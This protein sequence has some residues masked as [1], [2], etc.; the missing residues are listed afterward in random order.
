M[1]KPLHLL[2]R[3]HVIRLLRKLLRIVGL[4]LL[5]TGIV[6]GGAF[7]VFNWWFLP[8]L[9]QFRP[10]LEASL[11]QASGRQV[12]VRALSGEW[13]GVAPRLQLQGLR[14][15]NPVN[16]EALTLQQVLVVPSW[17]SLLSWQPL[18]S[19]IVLQGPSVALVR[20]SDGH[21]LL[22]GFDLSASPERSQSADDEPSANWLLRQKR[23]EIS[24]AHISWEDKQLGLPRLDLQRG[25][26]IL[27]QT[28]LG[29]RLSL[30]GK[31]VATLGKGFDMELSWRGNDLRQWRDWAGSARIRL[32]GAQAGMLS[33]YMEK[34][35]LV[36]SGEGSGTL[37]ADFSDGHVNSLHADVSIRNAAYTPR[38]AHTLVLPAI[39]GKLQLERSSDGIYAINA[40][41]L[42]LA[43]ASGLAF[44]NSSI[45]GNWLP[46]AQGYGQL[47]L[48]NV[49]VAHLTP[50]IRALGGD[51]NS[52]FS[53]FAPSGQLKNLSLSWKG[54]LQSP[55]QYVVASRFDQLAWQAFSSIPGV[56]GV[57][58][59]L[60]FGEQGGSLQLDS[61]HAALNYPAV[62]PQLLNFD[63]LNARVEWKNQGQQTDVDFHDV[64]F[65]NADLQGRFG[66][67]Y[68]HDGKGPGVV[69]FTA[70]V[71]KV[72]AIRVP[73]YL[74]HAVGEDTLRWLKQ[75]LLGGT[76]SDVRMI[77]KGDLAD[78][79][80]AGGKGGQFSVDA[81]VEQGKLLYEKGWPT[82]DNIQADLG[83]HNEKMLIAA[84]SGSTLGVPL[85][86]VEVGIDNLGAAQPVLTVQGHAQGALASMLKFTTSSP[87]DGW[88]DGFTGNLQAGGNAAL[89]LKLG[90][91]LSGP[92]PVR[93]R[94]DI[95]LAGNQL[96]FHTLPIPTL[97]DAHG[98]LTFTEHGV[99]TNGVAFNALGGPFLLKASS[100]PAG[101]MNFDIRGEADSKQALDR[102]L[103]MLSPYV[104]GRSPFAVQFVVQK[105][106]ESLQLSSSLQG[107]SI[108]APEPAGKQAAD[109]LPLSLRV[110]PGKTAQQP[111]RLDL[112]VG[113]VASGSL[114][115]DGHG[116]LKSGVIASGRPL[117]KQPDEGL[118]LRLA[119]PRVDVPRWVDAIAG[120]SGLHGN[121]AAASKS[122]QLELPLQIEL[123]TPQLD[124]WSGSLHKVTATLGNRRIHN[125]WSLD[126]RAHELS[127][128]ID[129]LP[130]GNGLVRANLAYALLNP[131]DKGSAADG[132]VAMSD[133]GDWPALDIRVGDLIYQNRSVGKLDLRARREGRD[134]VLNPL[135]LVAPEGS[136]QGSA[137]VRRSA[138]GKEVQTSY[139]LDS[140][141]VGKLLARVG[142]QDTFRKGEG[143][144]RGNMSWPGGL[145]DLSASQ[146]SGEMTLALKN[147]R[148]AKV[149]PGVARLLGVLSLQSLT[150]RVKLDFTDVFSDGFAFDSIT[151]DAHISKGVFVSDNVHMKGPAADVFL[152]GQVNLANETQDVHIKVQPHL[153]E[154][155]ALAAG[156]ALLNPV[157]GVAALAAQ[158][159]LQDPVGKILSV[160]YALTGSFANPKVEKQGMEPLRNSKRIITP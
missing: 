142:L 110:V 30:S 115:L 34:V 64:R 119:A 138:S 90:I 35:G 127:G 104:S 93:V 41:N 44:D 45:R 57:S 86:A 82:I 32:N 106:L 129:Y 81:K 88:L 144:L 112:E 60:R 99:E 101:R 63:Q 3:I 75:A 140:S 130:A 96:G 89:N 48:D 72:A 2:A 118:V 153:A 51:G 155:V 11:S 126:V 14:I 158:K 146:L 42:T 6:V 31:P 39:S 141:D 148:F 91:P 70:S 80:F 7:S 84:R 12:S 100:T 61:R 66:G 159:V 78:F 156:A 36:N 79:P 76:A 154:S 143:T 33:R 87:V 133:K 10:Q 15:A 77:L 59:S 50:F 54:P 4:L 150:R 132:D 13:Q 5:L 117:G 108:Q 38:D 1:E 69:D 18:F 25:Q 8:R 47:T 139:Q 151:G 152:R 62:F 9:E 107:S 58:G 157:V 17:W 29:H 73:A 83:F 128:S 103:P 74:P 134:W 137:R 120:P 98:T 135:R 121:G 22:N 111:V 52:L 56:S 147:G 123:D 46:G 160:E 71:D 53:R 21:I 131:P 116:N 105:G 114:L 24:Q 136:L 67:H 122:M 23:I 20:N 19:S 145:F 26:L 43:S 95:L 125:G 94:G 27:G 55:R 28:L 102:Y 68:H 85:S 113:S 149:D 40:S 37:E 49:N 16:G 65:A 97:R 124:G 109:V 92:Q